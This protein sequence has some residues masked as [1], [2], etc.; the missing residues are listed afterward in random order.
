MCFGHVMK[1]DELGYELPLLAAIVVSLFFLKWVKET[2]ET[3]GV[4]RKKLLLKNF[5]IYSEKEE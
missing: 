3:A 5:S 4:G 1:T 2:K